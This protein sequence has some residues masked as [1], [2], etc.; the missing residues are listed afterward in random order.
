V[1]FYNK[2]GGQ[3]LGIAPPNQT[4]PFEKLSLTKKEKKDLVFFMK[5]LT[6]TASIYP[7]TD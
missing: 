6:D 4:L 7:I 1:D 2:G 3:G 5:T